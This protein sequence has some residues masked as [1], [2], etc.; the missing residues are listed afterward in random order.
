MKIDAPVVV[1]PDTASKYA[2]IILMSGNENTKGNIPTKEKINHTS[3]VSNI[4]SRVAKSLYRGFMPNAI[5]I[6]ATTV[7]I[8]DMKN[9]LSESSWV[10]MSVIKGKSIKAASI[11]RSQ[12][13]KRSTM[14]K[15]IFALR[16]FIIISISTE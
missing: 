7:M 2:S 12:P 5:H 4:A 8:I 1:N 9:P 6:P 16:S 11:N 14:G 3:D 13:I 10:I 15:L